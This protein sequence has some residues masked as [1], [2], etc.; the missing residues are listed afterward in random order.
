ML[1]LGDCRLPIAD[2]RLVVNIVRFA[3]AFSNWHLAISNRQ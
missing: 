2:L 1:A 3:G